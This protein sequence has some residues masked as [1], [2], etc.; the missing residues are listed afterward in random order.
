MAEFHQHPDNWVYVRTAGGIYADRPDNF[1]ADFGVEL[2]PLPDGA[3]ERIYTQQRRHALMGDGNVVAGG[4]LPW[5][6]GDAI[7]A[8]IAEGLEAQRARRGAL[9]GV[10]VP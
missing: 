4:D 5:P 10:R 2:P 6:L 7:I 1:V 9:D 3:N 8:R